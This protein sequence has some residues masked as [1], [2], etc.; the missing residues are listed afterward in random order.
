MNIHQIVFP[1]YKLRKHLKIETNPLGLVK[2]TSIKG[3]Y[4]LDD[5]SIRGTFAERRVILSTQ[6]PK[7][8]LYTLKEKILYL[9]QLV[10]YK[11]GTVFIDYNGNIFKYKKG[12]RLYQVKSHKIEKKTPYGNWT[13]LKIIGIETPFLIGH[14]LLPTTTHASIMYTQWG[15]FLYDLTNTEHELYRRKI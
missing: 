3:T 2:I 13:I 12:N 11:S 4:I 15:P 8:K 9:R 6:Y 7:E 1:L 14:N 10:K 5:T